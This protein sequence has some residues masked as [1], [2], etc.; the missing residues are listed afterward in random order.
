MENIKFKCQIC[1]RLFNRKCDLAQHLKYGK[2][3]KCLECGKGIS[4]N[5]KFCSCSCS[6]TYNNR[7]RQVSEE[8]KLKTSKSLRSYYKEHP[9]YYKKHT[10][11]Y[12][13]RSV[14]K[15]NKIHVYCKSCNKEIRKNSKTGFCHECLRYSQNAECI[16][17][18]K[19]FGL[20]GGK[21]S[22]KSQADIRRSK[23]EM[24]FADLANSIYK[25]SINNKAIFNGWDA[26]II[27]PSLKIAIL[28][29]GKWHY[30]DICGQLKQ[31]QNRDRIKYSEIVKAG[32]MPYIITDLGKFSESKCLKE[33]ERFNNF[34]KLLNVD[35]TPRPEK[36]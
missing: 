22:A 32:Y 5:N 12:K 18:R 35:S 34:V 25:D 28:W 8:Q 21:A 19:T 6:V 13:R 23:N 24:F 7:L 31:V 26:D 16:E 36:N 20:K 3:S 4:G 1:D 10:H 2:H 9:F 33:L 27:I 17:L 14:S 11:S 30:E 29:N 15:P